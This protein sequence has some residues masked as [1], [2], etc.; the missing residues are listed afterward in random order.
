MWITKINDLRTIVGQTRREKVKNDDIREECGIRDV[1]RLS[2]A[3]TY[4]MSTSKEQMRP[5]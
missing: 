1:V 5:G 3:E 2:E 4:G